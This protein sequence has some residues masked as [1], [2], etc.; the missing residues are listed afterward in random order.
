MA[1]KDT[2]VETL[3]NLMVKDLIHR[4][5]HGEEEVTK[6]GDLVTVKIKAQTLSVIAKFLKDNEMK[7]PIDNPETDKL[8]TLLAKASKELDYTL[9]Q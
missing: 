3:W 5:E 8:A 4:L 7:A 9:Y 1:S 6:D 2:L